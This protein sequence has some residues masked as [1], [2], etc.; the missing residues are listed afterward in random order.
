MDDFVCG[1][2]LRRRARPGGMRRNDQVRQAAI[3]GW[4]P[5]PG[6]RTTIC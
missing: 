3:Q 2:L 1:K 5:R 6:R 4:F